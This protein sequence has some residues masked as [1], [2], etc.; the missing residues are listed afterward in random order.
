MECWL[1]VIFSSLCECIII[2]A[3]S[4]LLSKKK[5][6]KK[7]KNKNKRNKQ[8]GIPDY[9]NGSAWQHRQSRVQLYWQTWL[10]C[11]S[12]ISRRKI[13]DHYCRV[14]YLTIMNKYCHLNFDNVIKS[15]QNNVCY[16]FLFSEFWPL[17]NSEGHRQ[18]ELWKGS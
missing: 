2:I 9:W 18:G 11:V 13:P 1:T 3:L 12:G 15:T 10:I 6:S 14:F 7:T 5:K 8:I 4:D 17:S 16:F